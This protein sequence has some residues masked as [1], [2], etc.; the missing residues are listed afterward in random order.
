MKDAPQ[1]KQKLTRP[2]IVGHSVKTLLWRPFSPFS[3]RFLP[4]SPLRAKGQLRRGREVAHRAE[5]TFFATTTTRFVTTRGTGVSSERPGRGKRT[6]F[7]SSHG[8]EFDSTNCLHPF[9]E[10]LRLRLVMCSGKPMIFLLP[11]PEQR[12]RQKN[13]LCSRINTS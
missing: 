12:V 9:F 10:Q 13:R 11:S 4:S 6:P 2:N 3:F 7:L 8:V 1:E 5:V